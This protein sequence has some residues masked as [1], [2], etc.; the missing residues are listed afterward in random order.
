MLVSVAPESSSAFFMQ[1]VN[2]ERVREDFESSLEVVQEIKLKSRIR[3]TGDWA[4]PR[5]QIIFNVHPP[6]K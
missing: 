3:G 1:V 4:P 6:L 2:E 5:F